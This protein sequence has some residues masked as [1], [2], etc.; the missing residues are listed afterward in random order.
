M[1]KT[2]SKG[3]FDQE[4]ISM[5]LHEKPFQTKKLFEMKSVYQEW[6]NFFKNLLLIEKKNDIFNFSKTPGK[7]KLFI[8]LFNI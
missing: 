4:M 6:H 1:H 8:R 7:I 5:N 2:L 3:N